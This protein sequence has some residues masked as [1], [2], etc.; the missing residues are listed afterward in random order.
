MTQEKMRVEDGTGPQAP[1]DYQIFCLRN[2]R[3]CNIFT[4]IPWLMINVKTVHDEN[5]IHIFEPR[6]GF[7]YSHHTMISQ[8]FG[9]M[10]LLLEGVLLR[11][12]FF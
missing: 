2:S 10:K 3:I 9:E 4:R 12:I 7:H 8:S 6:C 1:L 5:D 11:M